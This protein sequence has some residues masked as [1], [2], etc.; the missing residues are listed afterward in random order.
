MEN[1]GGKASKKKLQAIFS[2]QENPLL[3]PCIKPCFRELLKLET[4]EI[5]KEE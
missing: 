4:A 2:C 1:K 3:H 5:K